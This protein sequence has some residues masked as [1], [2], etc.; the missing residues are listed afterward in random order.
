MTQQSLN[1]ARSLLQ[2]MGPAEA[3]KLLNSPPDLREFINSNR[4]E[5]DESEINELKA[6]FRA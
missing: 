3:A 2:A 5:L 6:E 4:F 1:A